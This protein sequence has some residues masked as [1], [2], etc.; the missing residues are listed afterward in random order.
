[1]ENDPCWPLPSPPIMKF[2]IILK[3]KFFEPFPKWRPSPYT[4]PRTIKLIWHLEHNFFLKFLH[5]CKPTPPTTALEPL[6]ATP[7]CCYQSLTQLQPH[8]CHPPIECE[9]WRR[10]SS[11]IFLII[12]FTKPNIEVSGWLYQTK[13]HFT[14]IVYQPFSRVSPPSFT[15]YGSDHR[16]H[17]IVLHVV[18]IWKD[19]SNTNNDG[20]IPFLFQI[21]EMLETQ[22]QV[23]SNILSLYA[24]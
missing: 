20:H 12:L 18:K 23:I 22:L 16:S 17:C 13:T 1:M 11:L 14:H 9:G 7:C 24:L 8:S 5:C 2:S 15:L 6:T 21:L 4:Y 3:K 19:D 10:H